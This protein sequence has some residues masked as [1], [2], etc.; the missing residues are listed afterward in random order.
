M[1]KTILLGI[2]A[3]LLALSLSVP[4]RAQDATPAEESGNA[5]REQLAAQE[6]A[7]VRSKK[8]E[9]PDVASLEKMSQEA[10]D[11]E[12]YVRYYGANIRMMNQRP[13]EPLYMQR[14]IE[15]SAMLERRRTA[16]HYMLK[17]QQQGLSYDLNDSKDAA[18]IRTTELFDYLNNLMIEAG[19][20]AGVAEPVFAYN[21]QFGKPSALTWDQ[22]RERFLLGTLADGA[23]IALMPDGSQ[24]VLMQADIDNGLWAV[25]GL[26]ADADN[27]R[28][29]VSTAAIPAFKDYS[30]ADMGR[31]AVLEFDLTTLQQVNRF[32]VPMD[33]QAHELGALAVTAAGDVY[34]L[35]QGL[36]MVFRKT[37]G[38]QALEPFVGS[39]D[40]DS[41]SAIAVS[42]DNR[43]LYVADRYK[44]VLVVDPV[45]QT[46]SMLAVPETL[47]MGRINS[48][49][50]AE[51]KLFMTQSGLRP[52]RLM[53]LSLDELGS[54]VGEA[55]PMASAL[56]NFESPGLGF[57][58]GGFVYYF[59]NEGNETAQPFQLVRTG[60]VT[61]D[62]RPDFQ[63][64][65][66][67]EPD[68]G[69]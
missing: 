33:N 41:L 60:L 69:D 37:A 34:V 15:A 59:A 2:A 32:N 28:L 65:N 51:R 40:M 27:N 31:G 57:F 7:P 35:D 56:E 13:Y 12:R 67:V 26:H 66:S 55:L 30:P 11:E 49:A 53:Q 61:A 63:L 25:K 14:V 48:L 64:D 54:G 23:I 50:Y 8:N 62:E 36:S 44:G 17:M 19:E 16:Y 39:E 29:W 38:G 5:T 4:V 10:Y 58:K 47:N 6:E 21:G 18:N 22:S 24:E 3:I 46:S 68:A 20:P 9:E 42:H 43:R 52:E 1:T 45:E